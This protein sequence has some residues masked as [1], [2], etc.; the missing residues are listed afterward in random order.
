MLAADMRERYDNVT[1]FFDTPDGKATIIFVEEDKGKIYKI[2]FT[3]GKAG[4]SINAWAFALAEMVA[5]SIRSGRD[6]ADI[7]SDLSSITS[8]RAVYTTN[9]L[10]CRSGP[11]AL[12]I[13][14]M[15]YRDMYKNVS[16]HKVEY[17]ENYRPPK[18]SS[19]RG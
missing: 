5:V 2:F 13:G 12:M 16:K 10:A 7:I 3:I 19:K 17:S 18:F 8:S 14:L 11:E 4:S 1:M 15:R 6:L 9:G